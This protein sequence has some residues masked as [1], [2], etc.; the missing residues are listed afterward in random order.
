MDQ[1]DAY[2]HDLVEAQ[3]GAVLGGELAEALQE[4]LVGD[5]EAG[6]AH[7]LRT[8]ESN[9][10]SALPFGDVAPARAG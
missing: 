7:H 10:S 8:I 4:R 6:V 1:S 5:D 9:S 3:H 2:R